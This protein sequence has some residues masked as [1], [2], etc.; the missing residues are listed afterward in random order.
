MQDFDE[1]IRKIKEKRSKMEMSEAGKENIR[2]LIETRNEHLEDSDVVTYTPK[3]NKTYILAQKITAVFVCCL[4]LSSCAFAGEW[5]DILTKIFYGQGGNIDYAVDNGYVQNIE[6]N[7]V[8]S[9]GIKIKADYFYLDDYYMYIAFDIVAEE[10]FDTV[11]L[12]KFEIVSE[13]NIIFSNFD[14][15]EKIFFQSEV[16]KI[17]KY[18]AIILGKFNKI[19]DKFYN[20]NNL[21]ININKI[22]LL[23]A[24]ESYNIDGIWNL[25]MQFYNDINYNDKKINYYIDS[26]N[27]VENCQVKLKNNII[28]INIKFKEKYIDV[29]KFSNNNNI[30][31]QDNNGNIYN[32]NG[33]LKLKNNEVIANFFIDNI[34]DIENFKL[35]LKYND[36]NMVLYIKGSDR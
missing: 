20:Y 2:K 6:M 24:D 29:E 10:E 28:N 3:R 36:E 25:S 7:Y 35:N 8:E 16:K 5:K 1:E 26:K 30:Y 23:N 33:S 19:Q 22:Q 15:S 9:N 11:Y 31:L 18:N 14:I 21:K 34:K 17:S 4:I 32:V 27:L 13:N 12:D